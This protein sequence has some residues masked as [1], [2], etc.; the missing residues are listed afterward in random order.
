MTITDDELKMLTDKSS[1][2]PEVVELYRQH[3]FLTAYGRHTDLRV[4]DDPQLAI[5]G[6]WEEYGNIQRDFLIAQG[7]KPH[8]RLLDLGCG[9]GRLARKIVPYLAYENYLGVDISKEAILYAWRLADDEGWDNGDTRKVG[10]LR[11]GPR[12]G[13]WQNIDGIKEQ[14][15]FVWA[16]SVFIHLPRAEIEESICAVMSKLAPGGKFYFSYVP[17]NLPDNTR[18]GLK[19]FKHP[20]SLYEKLAANLNY[21]LV[22]VPWPGRQRILEMERQ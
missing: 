21:S 11:R 12:F 9:T 13:C 16:F 22:E 7:L 8:H 3:D 15:D 18:T 17:T 2:D 6:E 19:Q 14:F 5:G 1:R 4:K 10:E 20:L